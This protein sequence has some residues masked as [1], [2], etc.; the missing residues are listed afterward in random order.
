VDIYGSD[1][2]DRPERIEQA[3]LTGYG[4]DVHILD[5]AVVSANSMWGVQIIP[6][7]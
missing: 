3:L 7:R 2:A 6:L 5:D 1:D 4:Y